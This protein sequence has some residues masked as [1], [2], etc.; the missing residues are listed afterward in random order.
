MIG[1]F[2]GK[3]EERLVRLMYAVWY[4]IS[5]GLARSDAGVMP[6]ATLVSANTTK[7]PQ[8]APPLPAQ[9]LRPAPRF[10]T[11]LLNAHFETNRHIAFAKSGFFNGLVDST[12]RHSNALRPDFDSIRYGVNRPLVSSSSACRINLSRFSR[13]HPRPPD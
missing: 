12:A 3:I 8:N 6:S 1:D 11:T 5:Q 9:L 2:E 13:H 4:R 7:T 10:Q